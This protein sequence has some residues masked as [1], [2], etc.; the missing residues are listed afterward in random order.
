MKLLVIPRGDLAMGAVWMA[1]PPP[2][3]GVQ[4][5]EA[6]WDQGSFCGL[7]LNVLQCREQWQKLAWAKVPLLPLAI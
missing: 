5:R 1:L 4:E 2:C 3:R 7:R 6:Q